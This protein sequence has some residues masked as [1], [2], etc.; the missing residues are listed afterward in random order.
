M[1]IGWI[2]FSKEEKNKI[3]ALIRMLEGEQAVDEIGIG[4]VRDSFSDMLFPGI[5]VLQTRAKYF[6][7]I[8]YLFEM[9]S[10]EQEKYGTF[11]NGK[12]VLKF[13]H[14]QEIE[15]VK[16]L[17]TNSPGEDGKGE[18]G[19]IG[20]LTSDGIVKQK[21]S[22]IYWSGIRETGILMHNDYSIGRV[23]DIIVASGNTRHLVNL[24]AED[25]ISGSD[26][27]EMKNDGYV[28]FH[29]ILVDYDVM[30]DTKI[31]LTKREAEYLYDRFTT[32]QGTKNSLM[33][34][35]LK[36]Q[37]LIEQYSY[38]D[39]FDIEEL[40]G[41]EGD[42]Y[43]RVRLAKDFSDFI[44][45][46]HTAYNML[47][48][49][50]LRL[51]EESEKMRQQLL[52]YLE[53]YKEPDLKGILSITGC[54]GENASFLIQLNDFAKKK[55]IEGISKLITAREQKIKPGKAKITGTKGNLQ[56][57]KRAHDYKLSY[58]YETARRI[59]TDIVN[60]MEG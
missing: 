22:A 9:A 14:N 12:D 40:K 27:R 45:G 7:L 58:R 57:Y 59:M 42:L 50:A 33:A 35:M 16:V 32:S 13:I 15:L 49:Q 43:D 56:E 47:F 31:T 54:V 44:I 6:V 2:D 19:I 60:G 1:Q 38:F 10:K 23:C 53:S 41:S 21:P 3:N 5:S 51:E 36:N 52:G 8:P 46:G 48:A 30:K 28:L 24:K 34:Y 4:Y 11:K 26:D 20:R 25:N 29:P 55:D 39:I 37:R 18:N 17:K